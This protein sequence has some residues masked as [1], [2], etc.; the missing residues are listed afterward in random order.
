MCKLQKSIYGLK[1]ASK[2]CYLNYDEVVIANC[3]KENIADVG[4]FT[5]HIRNSTSIMENSDL[6]VCETFESS[7]S[8]F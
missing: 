1:Q 5:T 7:K 2:Q 8:V 6:R 4:A 3:F